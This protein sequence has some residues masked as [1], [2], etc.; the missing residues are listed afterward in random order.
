MFS[1]DY[2]N[3]LTCSEQ[4]LKQNHRCAQFMSQ[5]LSRPSHC[6]M[7]YEQEKRPIR[8][9]A[10]QHFSCAVYSLY[11]RSKDKF[12]QSWTYV[13]V[14][15]RGNL[16]HSNFTSVGFSLNS[17][18]FSSMQFIFFFLLT[19]KKNYKNVLRMY[20]KKDKASAST[21]DNINYLF[22]TGPKI[23]FR[24]FFQLAPP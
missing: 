23:L 10:R 8:T 24:D 20:N 2:S 17:I 19:L 16:R 6:A 7:K 18:Q 13:M 21:N 15:F 22:P 14:A 12:S 11:R 3:I 5:S 4:G 9:C 1:R